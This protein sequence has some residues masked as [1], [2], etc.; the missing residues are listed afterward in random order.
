MDDEEDLDLSDATDLSSV[1]LAN[2][3]AHTSRLLL[4]DF[5][6]DE[7]I[8]DEQVD[9]EISDPEVAEEEEDNEEENKLSP[10]LHE[11]NGHNDIENK[12]QFTAS[13]KTI[14]ILP[15]SF[16]IGRGRG[17]KIFSQVTKVNSSS[18]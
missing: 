7:D 11:Q 8:D 9:E 1:L 2:P 3:E 5:S 4:N 18:S 6:S 12:D 13:M 17:L 14:P 10:P 16:P 15:T